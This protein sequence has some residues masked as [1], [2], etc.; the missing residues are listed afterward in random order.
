MDRDGDLGVPRRAHA[1]VA[2]EVVVP[3]VSVGLT[4]HVT[5]QRAERYV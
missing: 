4:R 5:P 2:L 3:V 1:M